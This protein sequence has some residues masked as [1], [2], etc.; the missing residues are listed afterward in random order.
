MDKF[1][2]YEL[3]LNP[4]NEELT[5]E[6]P[7]I[8]EPEDEQEDPQ[9]ITDDIIEEAPSN[10]SEEDGQNQADSAKGNRSEDHCSP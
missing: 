9:P 1:S 6:H 3:I 2:G 8:E 4:A 10:P 5:Q 7:L